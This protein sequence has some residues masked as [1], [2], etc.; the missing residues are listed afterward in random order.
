MTR[1]GPV[2]SPGPLNAKGGGQRVRG[3]DSRTET[4]SERCY[5][6]ALKMEEG[7]MSPGMLAASRH[8]KVQLSG[9]FPLESNTC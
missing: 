3:K 2:L 6:V 9:L 8:W 4:G 5:I 7:T 1:V